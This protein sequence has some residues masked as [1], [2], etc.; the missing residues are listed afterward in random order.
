MGR[1]PRR[2][3]FRYCEPAFFGGLLDDPLL[4]LRI[5]PEGQAL[6][7]DCGQIAHLA[8]RVVKPIIAVFIT[9][10]HMDHIMGV[11]TFRW[12]STDRRQ[13]P[14]GSLTSCKV[15]TGTCASQPGSPCGSTRSTT[16]GYGITGSPDPRDSFNI[17]TA[18]RPVRAG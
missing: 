14:N 17:T 2:P 5:R 9:H 6:L 15:S 13:S 12:T 11:P 18:K 16:T 1:E 8:K 4:Y 7:F 3:P 10:A